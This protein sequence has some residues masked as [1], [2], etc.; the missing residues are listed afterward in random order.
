MRTAQAY[1][2]NAGLINQAQRLFGTVSA[3]ALHL[4]LFSGTMPTDD[5]LTALLGTASQS[6]LWSAGTIAAFA[7][8]GNFLADVV[9]PQ[10]FV[11][12]TDIENMQMSFPLSAQTATFTAAQAGTPTWFLLR[13]SSAAQTSDAWAGFSSG[14]NAYTIIVGTVGDE[15]SAADLKI[16]GGAVTMNTLA[17]IRPMDLRLKY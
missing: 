17:P 12:V 15:N 7:T 5:Q 14:T 13:I 8:T 4:A 1:N 16:V 3:N 9:F 6:V 10:S 2:R 11:P